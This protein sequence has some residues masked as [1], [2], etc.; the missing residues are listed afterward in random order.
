MKSFVKILLIIFCCLQNANAQ[1]LHS[2]APQ[3]NC[4]TSFFVDYIATGKVNE[5][6]TKLIIDGEFV[7]NTDSIADVIFYIEKSNPLKKETNPLATEIYGANIYA[8]SL[9]KNGKGVYFTSEKRMNV[10]KISPNF[11]SKKNSLT[12]TVNLQNHNPAND[13]ELILVNQVVFKNGCKYV[14]KQKITI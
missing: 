5:N 11:L 12:I 4:A 9:N 13:I 3:T 14:R 8:A 1:T 6:K 7:A 10:L 2:Y